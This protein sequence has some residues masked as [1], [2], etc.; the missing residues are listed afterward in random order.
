MNR[1]YQHETSPSGTDVRAPI[2]STDYS[3][4]ILGS[5]LLFRELIHAVFSEENNAFLLSSAGQYTLQY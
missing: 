2:H 5:L 4:C 3:T 1:A